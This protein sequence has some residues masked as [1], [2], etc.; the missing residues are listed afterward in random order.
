MRAAVVIRCVLA[1]VG[2]PALTAAQPSATPVDPDLE[3]CRAE[4]RAMYERAIAQ[5][6]PADRARILRASFGG[7]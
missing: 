4:R 3:A 5:D 7:G 6:D 1:M 2:V